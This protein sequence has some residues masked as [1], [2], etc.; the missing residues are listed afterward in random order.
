MTFFFFGVWQSL[1]VGLLKPKKKKKKTQP[2]ASSASL[3][4]VQPTDISACM[5]HAEIFR[6]ER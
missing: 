4:Q 6:N 5:D 2:E 3:L 1:Q